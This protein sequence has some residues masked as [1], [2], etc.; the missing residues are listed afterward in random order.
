MAS[1][2]G[3]FTDQVDITKWNVCTRLSNTETTEYKD[4]PV[5][6]LAGWVGVQHTLFR[7]FIYY[8][9]YNSEASNQL[10]ILI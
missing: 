10:N 7:N 5:L 3:V 8:F 6:I 1:A 9:L 2:R 4:C